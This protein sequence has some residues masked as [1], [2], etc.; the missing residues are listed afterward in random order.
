LWQSQTPVVPGSLKPKQPPGVEAKTQGTQSYSRR[1]AK[2]AHHVLRFA[3][4]DPGKRRNWE[5]W[6]METVSLNGENVLVRIYLD[7]GI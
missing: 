3:F 5:N 4:G 6:E 1:S 7:S 2:N